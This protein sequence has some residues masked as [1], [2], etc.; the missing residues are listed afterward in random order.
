MPSVSTGVLDLAMPSTRGNSFITDIAV[1]CL[2]PADPWLPTAAW[3]RLLVALD[4]PS[5][6]ARTSLHRMD[7]GGYLDRT[8]RDGVPGYGMSPSWQQ[9]VRARREVATADVEQQTRWVLVCFSVPESQRDV[10]HT[11]RTVLERCGMVP[12]GNGTWIGPEVAADA[13]DAMLEVSGLDGYTDVF[14]AEHRADDVALAR[15]CWDL[16]TMTKELAAYEAAAREACSEDLAAEAAF[17]TVVSLH[18]AWRRLERRVPTLPS[19][20]FPPG[21]SRSA[22]QLALQQLLEARLPAVQQWVASL[23]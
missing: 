21:G 7:K 4:L 13:V 9:F 20:M 22:S 1:L 8:G 18:N 6:T 11:L 3:V 15:R 23:R 2:D 10:R 14:L 16:E 17:V 5:A 19:R 12:L